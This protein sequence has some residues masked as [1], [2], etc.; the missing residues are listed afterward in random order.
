MQH[1]PPLFHYSSPELHSCVTNALERGPGF[2]LVTDFT[3]SG[4]ACELATKFCDFCSEFGRLVPQH[5]DGTVVGFLGPGDV[6][7]RAEQPFHVDGAKLLALLCIRKA[8]HGGATRVL[9]TERLCHIM[10]RDW[11]KEY[12]LLKAPWPFWRKGRPGPPVFYKPI[13]DETGDQYRFFYLPNTLKSVEIH[14]AIRLSADQHR[15]LNLL[16]RLILESDCSETFMLESGTI[17]L[18]NNYRTMHARVGY[19]D[20]PCGNRNRLLLRCW[21]EQD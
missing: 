9:S 15:T 21:I 11:S 12:E 19:E 18:A 16:D 1:P 7:W 2:A 4:T 3:L 14:T 6:S 20:C 17:L 13:V 10:K 8:L 5:L